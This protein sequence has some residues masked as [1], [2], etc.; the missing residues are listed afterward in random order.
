MPRPTE[1]LDAAL[2]ARV[3]QQPGGWTIDHLE[4]LIRQHADRF[5]DRYDEWQSYVFYLREFA[6]AS[7]RLP[8]KFDA[9][10]SE[11]FD[12]VAQ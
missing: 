11:V 12:P 1:N 10:L 5:P 7:G 9:L 6:D 8:E 3:P 2:A 4:S